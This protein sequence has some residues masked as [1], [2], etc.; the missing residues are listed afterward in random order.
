ML[1]NNSLL[2]MYLGIFTL[3][4]LVYM[5]KNTGSVFNSHFQSNIKKIKYKSFNFFLV[6]DELNISTMTILSLFKNDTKLNI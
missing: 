6:F 2:T 4:F 1:D 5:M 3:N